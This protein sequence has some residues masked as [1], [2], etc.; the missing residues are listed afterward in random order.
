MLSS[1]VLNFIL[2]KG[3]G[4]H[5]VFFNAF[6]VVVVCFFPLII[7]GMHA[8]VKGALF[9]YLLLAFRVQTSRI[10]NHFTP[11]EQS[12]KYFRLLFAEWASL[13]TGCQD[14]Q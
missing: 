12:E 2:K 7:L 3:G 10:H 11:W 6:F 8:C 5:V 1:Y 14:E 4:F 9:L 13:M